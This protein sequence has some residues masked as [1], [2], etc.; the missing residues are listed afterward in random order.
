MKEFFYD[1]DTIGTIS[2]E[3][4]RERVREDLAELLAVEMYDKV[5][6]KRKQNKKVRKLIELSMLYLIKV[7]SYETEDSLID[8]FGDDLYAIYK[9][10]AREQ[11]EYNYKEWQEEQRW[12]ARHMRG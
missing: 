7:M 10:E 11:Q 8:D 12:Q 2:Y 3:V 9:N 1:F 4:P 6:K 5:E